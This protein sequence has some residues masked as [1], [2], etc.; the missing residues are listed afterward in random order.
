MDL[1]MGDTP[2]GQSLN[3]GFLNFLIHVEQLMV[4]FYRVT[5]NLHILFV[6]WQTIPCLF[7]FKYLLCF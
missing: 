4:N 1:S 7:L 2:K 3:A 6:H 5:V